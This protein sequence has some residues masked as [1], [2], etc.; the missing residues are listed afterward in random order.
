MPVRAEFDPVQG[1]IGDLSLVKRA[2]LVLGDGRL[3]HPRQGR[4]TYN[5]MDTANQVAADFHT[6]YPP[7]HDR[8]SY[9]RG[10]HAEEWWCYP[11]H[12]D[13]IGPCKSG[14]VA[15]PV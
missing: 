13:P 5:S 10:L 11:H 7:E 8:H 9:V 3:F 15:H 4:Y 1:T 14:R 12:F 2:L 6:A